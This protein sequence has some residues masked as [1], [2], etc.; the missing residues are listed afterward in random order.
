[1]FAL[2]NPLLY[3]VL[4]V[5]MIPAVIQFFIGAFNSFGTTTQA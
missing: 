2:I 5:V 1:M 3:A 4:A